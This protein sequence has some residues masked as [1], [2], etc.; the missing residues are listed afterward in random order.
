MYASIL[1]RVNILLNSFKLMSEHFCSNITCCLP[2]NYCRLINKPRCE[3][4]VSQ[5][6]KKAG[7]TYGLFTYVAWKRLS[8]FLLDKNH[9]R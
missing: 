4:I 1:L 3:I 7:R 5:I 9:Q 6:S 8:R 2:E